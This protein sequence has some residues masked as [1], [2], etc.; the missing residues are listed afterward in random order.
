MVRVWYEPPPFG[1]GTDLNR[2]PYGVQGGGT[3]RA[4]LERMSRMKQP[5]LM[6][7]GVVFALCVSY[8]PVSKYQCV[9]YWTHLLCCYTH[10]RVRSCASSPHQQQQ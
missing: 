7:G 2:S 10:R 9:S 4:F 3:S 5:Y 8:I 1:V 6:A